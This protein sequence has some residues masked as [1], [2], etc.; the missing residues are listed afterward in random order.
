VWLGSFDRGLICFDGVNWRTY[1]SNSITSGTGGLPDNRVWDVAVGPDGAVWV[2]TY[3]GGVTRLEGADFAHPAWTTFTTAHGLPS[4]DVYRFSVALDG[5]AWVATGRGIAHFD[6]TQWTDYAVGEEFLSIGPQTI[7]AASGGAVWLGTDNGLLYFD[8]TDWQT[9]T[10]E[11]LGNTY[12][13]A[14]AD[15]GSVWGTSQY[16]VFR[17]ERGDMG[18]A[19]TTYP[20]DQARETLLDS[21]AISPDGSIWVSRRVMLEGAVSWIGQGLWRLNGTQWETF[22]T[23]D[24][25]VAN[26]VEHALRTADGMLW[27]FT[28][29][30]ISCFRDTEWVTCPGAEMGVQI[31]PS[32][33]RAPDDALWTRAQAGIARFDG[34]SWVLYD[35]LPGS[36]VGNLTVAPDG[37]IWVGTYTALLHVA[38]QGHGVAR[39]D[40]ERWTVYTADG[41]RGDSLADDMV[42]DIAAAADGMIW[43]ATRSGVSRF[44]GNA[45]MTYSI[46]TLMPANDQSYN[47]IRRVV[48]TPNGLVCCELVGAVSCFDG[49][50]WTGCM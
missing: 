7:V 41:E 17:F 6:G 1:T 33:A 50:G 45:W 43:V 14:T 24:E 15:D 9:Y 27:F 42:N 18:T 21:I 5:T 38:P 3:E 20:I 13:I 40:N 46:D 34:A 35:D 49:Q 23:G 2:S 29:G 4:N 36:S 22:V 30:G 26:R 16:G 8:G 12:S 31:G 39:F 32:V 48:T 10:N 44:D 11:S 28:E 25:L 47:K 37:S 19:W